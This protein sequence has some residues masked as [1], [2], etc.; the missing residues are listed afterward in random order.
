MAVV[1]IKNVTH[2]DN[3]VATVEKAGMSGSVVYIFYFDATEIATMRQLTSAP[4]GLL[5]STAEA[6]ENVI[7][8]A[9]NYADIWVDALSSIATDAVIETAHAANL[10]VGCWTLSSVANIG[11]A[12]LRNMDFVTADGIAKLPSN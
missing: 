10:P 3:L 5:A 11:N 12:F 9:P 4:I 8:Q 1:E 6:L 2:Y 7:N